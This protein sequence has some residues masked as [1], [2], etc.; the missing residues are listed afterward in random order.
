MAKYS[1]F[2]YSV[3]YLIGMLCQTYLDNGQPEIADRFF[4]HGIRILDENEP[5]YNEIVDQF[6]DLKIIIKE[7]LKNKK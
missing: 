7:E 4:N 5:D 2:E 6:L 3:V 1:N